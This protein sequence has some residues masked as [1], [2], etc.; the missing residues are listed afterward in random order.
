MRRLAIKRTTKRSR[1]KR[2]QEFFS[3]PRVYWFI[4]HYLL[5]RMTWP[6]IVTL[7]WI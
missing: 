6:S 7:Q 3:R 1:R 2:E 4:A 5:L